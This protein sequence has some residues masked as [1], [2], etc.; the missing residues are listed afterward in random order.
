MNGQGA[1]L[2][3]ASR[4][5]LAETALLLQH[6]KGFIFLPLL[7]QSE[8]AGALALELLRPA[9]STDPY[10]VAWPLSPAHEDDEALREARA[11]ADLA[12]LLQ[13]LDDATLR[14][15]PGSALLIDAASSARA[16]VARRLPVFLNQRRED[17]RHLGR[18]VLLLWPQS[19]S[20]S[21]MQG[22]PDLWSMRAVAPWIEEMLGESSDPSALMLDQLRPYV[23]TEVLS[24]AQ[25][26]QWRALQQNPSW[27]EADVSAAD[28][29]ALVAAL[30]ERQQIGN[31]LDLAERAMAAPE[32]SGQPAQWRASLMTEL[33]LLRRAAG[34]LMGALAPAQEAVTIRRRLAQA[35]PA[36]YEPVLAG[37]LWTAMR[38]LAATDQPGQA[39]SY[40]REALQRFAPLAA[41]E[42]ARFESH[43]QAVEEELRSLEQR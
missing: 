27:S 36:A 40:G 12:A 13:T 32:A 15:P 11:Q 42:P 39:L 24:P 35:N 31:G 14:L 30:R 9:L 29:L 16:A 22:A 28:L 10:R 6:A 2:T 23:G 7:V 25:Q 3:P 20:D 41:R 37:S 17:W 8:R 4:Q 34:D 43:R 1:A 33:V 26:R 38:C 5:A 19:S 21:L 18:R